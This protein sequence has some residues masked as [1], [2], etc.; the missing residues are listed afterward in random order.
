MITQHCVQFGGTDSQGSVHRV[1]ALLVTCCC[2]YL[3]YI[4]L[5]GLKLRRLGEHTKH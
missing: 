3:A 4:E 1:A 2:Q 5:V